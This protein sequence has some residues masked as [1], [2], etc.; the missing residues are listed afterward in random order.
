M[1]PPRSPLL[2]GL[3]LPSRTISPFDLSPPN[4][5][6][7][8]PM[9]PGRPLSRIAHLTHSSPLAVFSTLATAGTT[10]YVNVTTASHETATMSSSL[11]ELTHECSDMSM[12]S[13]SSLSELTPDITQELSGMSAH[14][15]YDNGEDVFT[16]HI[17]DVVSSV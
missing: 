11:P 7:D 9:I 3:V 1:L 17:I 14:V 2:E 5:R 6:I 8:S 10:E 13:S 15:T 4:D 12:D 16:E